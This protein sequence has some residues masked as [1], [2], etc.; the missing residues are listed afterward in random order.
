M[1][2]L[3]VHGRC[4]TTGCRI[5]YDTKPFYGYQVAESISYF[6]KFDSYA[7]A[8]N[9]QGGAGPI[10]GEDENSCLCDFTQ[11]TD[12]AVRGRQITR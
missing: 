11:T 3:G 8:W 5:Y 10:Q 9:M 4:F 6:E 7:Y 2:G 1:Q 12:C